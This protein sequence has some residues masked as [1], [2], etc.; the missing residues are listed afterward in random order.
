MSKV[1]LSEGAAPSTP[2]SAKVVIY[3]KTDGKLYAKDDGGTEYSVSQ[4]GT[5]KTAGKETIW[6]PAA[7]MR[8]TVSNGCAAITDA[9]TTA[10]RPDVTHLAFDNTADEHAQFSIAFPKSWDEGTIT[11]QAF[12]TGVAAGAGGVAWG[13]QG[14]AVSNDDTMDVAY[15][16]AI[17]VTDTFIAIEDLHVTSESSAVTIAG[18][19]AVDDTCFFRIFREFL[20]SF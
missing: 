2:S 12:W 3:A 13:L 15:G 19:P 14:V 9:E 1:T 5:I 7:A 20:I 4:S 17:V 18:T 8:P 11:F 10:G 6:V 16:T